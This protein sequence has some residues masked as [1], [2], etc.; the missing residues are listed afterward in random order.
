[1][2]ILARVVDL[3]QNQA[4]FFAAFDSPLVLTIRS[5]VYIS[6]SG[7]FRADDNDSYDKQLYA[8]SPQ[9]EVRD[10]I[11]PIHH[12]WCTGEMDMYYIV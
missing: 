6:R 10:V 9:A 4:S 1:M 3:K 5:D 12:N 11:S 7:N 8:C 2:A